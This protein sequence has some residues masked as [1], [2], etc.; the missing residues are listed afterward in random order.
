MATFPT[1]DAVDGER[2][3]LTFKNAG[4]KAVAAKEYAFAEHC[5]TKGIECVKGNA[6]GV[7]EDGDAP[8]HILHSNRAATRVRRAETHKRG[9]QEDVSEAFEELIEAAL[10]DG[11]MAITL[12]PE[13]ARGYQRCAEAYLM[14]CRLDDAERVLE[15]GDKTIRRSIHID[16]TEEELEAGSALTPKLVEVRN[17]IC[18]RDGVNSSSPSIGH[19]SRSHRLM[20]ILRKLRA[21]ELPATSFRWRMY[22]AGTLFREAVNMME[23]GVG[24]GSTAMVKLVTAILL[25]SASGSGVMMFGRKIMEDTNRFSVAFCKYWTALPLTSPC[26]ASFEHI[27]Q[28]CTPVVSA[29]FQSSFNGHQMAIQLCLSALQIVQRG[30]RDWEGKETAPRGLASTGFLT[31]EFEAML[32]LFYI[33]ILNRKRCDNM[34]TSNPLSDESLQNLSTMDQNCIMIEQLVPGD[35]WTAIAAW[36]VRAGHAYD[37][38]RFND[39][40][41]FYKMCAKVAPDDDSE[42]A[43]ANYEMAFTAL[44]HPLFNRLRRQGPRHLA[45]DYKFDYSKEKLLQSV[46]GENNTNRTFVR[47]ILEAEKAEAKLAALWGGVDVLHEFGLNVSGQARHEVKSTIEGMPKDQWD[48]MYTTAFHIVEAGD[49]SHDQWQSAKE[50]MESESIFIFANVTM[51]EM[52][53]YRAIEASNLPETPGASEVDFTVGTIL[54]ADIR[55]THSEV[56]AAVHKRE[57]MGKAGK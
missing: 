38:G 19:I 34:H 52:R 2:L 43:G 28:I 11:Q 25:D 1:V 48:H 29:L 37:N 42:K 22:Q 41:N 17:A 56:C 36:M 30:R 35:H 33:R 23:Q 6:S 46:T 7:E 9:A 4:G 44:Q 27:T 32:R 15:D 18:E 10:A 51:E 16:C 24:F 3:S 45:P 8:L 26:R 21:N 12:K 40:F 53:S 20:D 50:F 47:V 54:T 14:A 31:A 13:W 5:Y 39:A 57:R 55:S 49:E